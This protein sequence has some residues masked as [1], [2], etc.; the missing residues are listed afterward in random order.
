MLG[1][2]AIRKLARQQWQAFFDH[3]PGAHYATLDVTSPDVGARVRERA[4]LLS[5]ITYEPRTQLLAI[6][7]EGAEHLVWRPEEVYVDDPFGGLAK[8]AVR[9]D[10]GGLQIIALRPLRRLPAPRLH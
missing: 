8:L 2:M 7:C 10:D 9:R 4:T 5:A 6:W 3:L 1:Q